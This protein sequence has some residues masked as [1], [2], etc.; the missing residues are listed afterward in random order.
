MNSLKRWGV[1]ASARARGALAGGSR[2]EPHHG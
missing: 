1:L 2:L